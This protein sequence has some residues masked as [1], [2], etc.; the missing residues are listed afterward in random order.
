MT[1]VCR[2]STASG[3]RVLFI[4]TKAP[5]PTSDGGRLLMWHTLRELFA[6]G[7][8][9]TFV[10]PD[11][12]ATRQE[13]VE[14]IARC[15]RPRLVPCRPGRLLPSI[16]RAQLTRQPMSV[17]RH[18]HSA[19]QRVIGAELDQHEYD[20]IHAEQVQSIFNVPER[21]G[22]PP[23]V[24]RAQNVESHL[25]RMVAGTRPRFRWIARDEAR[26]MAAAEA[27]AVRM[28]SATIALTRRDAEALAGG[29][30]MRANR[31]HIIPPL[32]PNDLPAG[33]EKLSGAPPLLL[34]G[35]GWLPNRDSI[36][37]FFDSI[38]DDVRRENPKVHAHVFG[39]DAGL[40]TP[41]TSWHPSPSDSRH[42]FCSGAILVVPLRIASGIRMKIIE[43]WARG[44]PV[45][46]TPEAVRGLEAGDGCE[47]LL[48]R[49]GHE[50]ANAIRR[51][52][53][54]A[55]LRKQLTEAGRKMVATRHD[56]A[57]IVTLLEETYQ[58]VQR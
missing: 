18:T 44:I 36:S 13:A 23:I 56:P 5:F 51:L 10:A 19:L 47:L 9:V 25:W 54:E 33:S 24:L 45:V 35:G 40:S 1:S 48:A 30:G 6:R 26:K 27:R 22:Q 58:A 49:D 42:I 14:Q 4:A 43:S 32:F 52:N 55:D 21:V 57:R 12:G 15:C 28:A 34:L 31:L 46:A 16:F 39:S 11:L 8:R 37:W 50:F 7:H 17:L 3:M 29:R 41:G 20:I 38:W 53:E 2:P